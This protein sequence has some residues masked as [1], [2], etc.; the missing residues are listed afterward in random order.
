MERNFLELADDGE[1][2]AGEEGVEIF[3]D[4]QGRLDLLDDHVQGVERV[5][6]GGVALFLGLDGSARG[7]Q[8]GAAAPLEDLL[9]PFAAD[10][11][12]EVLDAQLLAGDDIENRVARADEGLELGLEV[13]GGEEVQSPKSKVQSRERVACGVLR[14]GHRSAIL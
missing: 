8:A 9:L 14:S 2:A 10:F 7:H 11:E 1:I 13:H 12:N 3:E 5:A 4:E 6:R